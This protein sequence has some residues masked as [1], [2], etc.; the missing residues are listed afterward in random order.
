MRNK[1]KGITLIALIITIIVM[2]ILVGVVVTVVI[3]SNLLG[4]AKTAGDK[5]KTAYEDESNMS[6]V[7]INGEKYASIEDYIESTKPLPEIKAGERASETSKYQTAVIPKGF[8]VSNATGE[9]D[10][11]TGLVIYDIPENEIENIK[12]DGTEKTQYNQFVWIPVE[13]NKT[14]EPKDTETS[15]ASFKRSVWQD[16][17]RVANNA[18]SSTSFPS[19]SY[20]W[21]NYTEPYSKDSSDYDGTGTGKTGISAQITELTQSIYKY[22]G[23]YIGRYEAGSETER[24][25]SSGVTTLGIKQDMYPYIYVKWGDSMG[26]IGTTGAVYLSNSLYTGKTGYGVKSM[27][28]TGAAWDSMLDFIKD[29]SHNVTSSP[30]WGNYKYSDTYKVYRGSLYSNSTWS[31]ADTT[32]GSDVTKDTSILLTTGATERNSS[33]NIYDVAGNC[34]EWTTEARNASYRV[35]RGGNYFY[36]GSSFPA[37]YRDGSCGPTFSYNGCS[38]RPLLYV[39]L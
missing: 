24:T 5:Y 15:I 12:W 13:V 6:E 31:V 25:N 36:D 30:S 32:N 8:T 16:N 19:S 22:G 38:F 23:F 18:Q 7:T 10:V 4:T 14:T 2:L 28:C 35:F 20:S 27:L 34:Y 26:N 11:S 21:S 39:A 17:A 29:S 3:Q 1:E 33:K 37:S 9:K